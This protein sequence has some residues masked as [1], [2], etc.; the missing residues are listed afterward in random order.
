MRTVCW[1]GGLTKVILN[2]LDLCSCCPHVKHLLRCGCWSCWTSLRCFCVGS[3]PHKEA[4]RRDFR[5]W[6]MSSSIPLCTKLSQCVI[7]YFCLMMFVSVCKVKFSKV[8]GALHRLESLCW[9]EAFHCHVVGF[10]RSMMNKSFNSSLALTLVHMLEICLSL[11]MS[12]RSFNFFRF[13]KFIMKFVRPV[14][15]M[16]QAWTNL[17]HSQ[18]VVIL[19]GQP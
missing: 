3:V 9:Y 7:F 1:S 19:I 5:L 15:W 18:L 10:G 8:V 6:T 2:M 12:D 14:V 4:E 16:S 17:L 11:D 13:L